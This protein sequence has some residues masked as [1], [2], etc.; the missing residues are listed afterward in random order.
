MLKYKY[1]TNPLKPDEN[2]DESALDLT[3]EVNQNQTAE[4]GDTTIMKSK[5]IGKRARDA[6][7]RER[8]REQIKSLHFDLDGNEINVAEEMTL[9]D[10]HVAKLVGKMRQCVTGSEPLDRYIAKII[11]KLMMKKSS[12]LIVAARD[13]LE[14]LYKDSFNE[15]ILQ[16]AWGIVSRI[17]SSGQE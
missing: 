14:G 2:D 9:N 13:E 17:N 8:F 10:T 7:Q 5:P 11:T 6:E 3:G 16:E 12:L 15:D 4:N 1:M